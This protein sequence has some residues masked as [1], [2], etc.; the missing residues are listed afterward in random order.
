[1]YNSCIFYTKVVSLSLIIVIYQLFEVEI[2]WLI[3]AHADFRKE[4]FCI[5]H[6]IEPRTEYKTIEIAATDQLSVIP[7]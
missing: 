2:Y 4:P 7:S 5:D 1:M 3:K 6:G